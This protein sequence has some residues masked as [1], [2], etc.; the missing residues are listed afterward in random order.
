MAG[1][2]LGLTQ[3]ARHRESELA[4]ARRAGDWAKG[5]DSL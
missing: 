2:N 5:G 4:Q 3:P 1:K